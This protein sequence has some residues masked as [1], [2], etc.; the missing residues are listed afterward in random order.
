M[1][2]LVGT[3]SDSVSYDD[4]GFTIRHLQRPERLNTQQTDSQGMHTGPPRPNN[5]RLPLPFAEV[6]LGGIALDS[7]G[8]IAARHDIALKGRRITECSVYASPREF[9]MTKWTDVE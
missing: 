1:G 2:K 8:A 6:M 5:L 7:Y 4:E 3:Q 9:A